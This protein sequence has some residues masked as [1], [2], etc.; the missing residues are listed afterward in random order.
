MH[1][2]MILT[3]KSSNPTG[4]E[5]NMIYTPGASTQYSIIIATIH[6][7]LY[8]NGLS[9]SM[10]PTGCLKKLGCLSQLTVPTD[11]EKLCTKWMPFVAAQLVRC[12]YRKFCHFTNFDSLLADV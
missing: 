2:E 1:F 3:R 11:T 12:W 4:Y 7:N 5:T 10:C 6:S 8:A 9:E